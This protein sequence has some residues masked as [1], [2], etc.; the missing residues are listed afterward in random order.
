MNPEDAA[1]RA[2]QGWRFINAGADYQLLLDGAKA[3]I[4]TV[5]LDWQPS[6]K[7]VRTTSY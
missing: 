3:G 5:D 1:D 2:A 6:A 7:R 4:D